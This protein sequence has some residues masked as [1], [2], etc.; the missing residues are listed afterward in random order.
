MSMSE[1]NRKNTIRMGLQEPLRI[2]DLLRESRHKC[3]EDRPESCFSPRQYYIDTHLKY[4]GASAILA[5]PAGC[6]IISNPGWID[7]R[8]SLLLS[9]ELH[10]VKFLYKSMCSSGLC[11]CQCSARLTAASEEMITLHMLG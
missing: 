4:F 11:D 5:L 3:M 2:T 6:A 9:R 7:I 8:S 1:R 10:V